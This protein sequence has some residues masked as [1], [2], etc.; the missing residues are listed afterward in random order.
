MK[1]LISLLMAITILATMAP[2]AL[3]VS[4][5]E[6]TAPELTAPTTE[7]AAE[8]ATPAT[9]PGTL[10]SP[11]ETPETTEV[12]ETTEATETTETTEATEETEATEATATQSVPTQPTTAVTQPTSSVPATEPAV[13]TPKAVSGFEVSEVTTTTVT[14]QWKA[15]S[16]A[17]KYIIYR[18][19]E[20]SKGKIS[21]YKSYKTI[22][23][24]SATTF[25]D[26]KL[27]VGR[28]YKYKIYAYRVKNGVTTHSSAKSLST[29]TKLK[30]LDTVK[31]SSKTSSSVTLNWSKSSKATK[32]LIYRASEKAN[33]SMGRYKFLKEVKGSKTTYIDATPKSGKIYVYR[34]FARR[35]KGKITG[36]SMGKSVK[37]VTRLA[38]SKSIK[39]GEVSTSGITVTWKKISGADKYQ[40]FRKSP[41]GKY[42][43]IYT[44]ASTSYRDTNVTSGGN[45]TYRVRGVRVIN[46]KNYSGEYKKL[47][48]SA[49]VKGVKGL[50]VKSYLR[51]GLFTWSA[52]DGATGYDVYIQRANGKYKYKDTVTSPSYLTGKLTTGKTYRYAIKSYKKINGSKVY[53][54]TRK[55]KVNISETA[56]GKTARGTYVEICTETQTMYMYV[57]N[58]LYVS[59]PV[60]TGMYNSQDTTHGYHRVMSR[61]SP[62]RLRGSANGHSWDVNVQ[63]W[64]GFTSDGQGIHDSSWRTSGYGGTIYKGDGSNGC[65]NTPYSAVAKIYAKAYVGM[66][67]IVY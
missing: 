33:G 13:I 16:D 12:T 30:T 59:T 66:P 25:E 51:R 39:S 28:V 62:A 38:P 2:L 53:G 43:K 24:K 1:K 32:I 46:G 23:N 42:K 36:T 56:F 61:K 57:K 58:K 11:T 60:V 67:V 65:V 34:V 26:S 47:K 14:L 8:E 7:N 37:T 52:V 40:L 22:N 50:Q 27:K 44:T 48:T 4:A 29:M 35:I 17:T 54:K 18:A 45:Y 20:D 63:Y 6:E 5:A 55:A 19:A 31:V 41:G 21:G 15:S 49:G 9:E 10:A 3:T 64:L